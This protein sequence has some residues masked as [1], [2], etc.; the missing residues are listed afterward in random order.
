MFL[1]LS[2]VVCYSVKMDVTVFLCKT[3]FLPWI[4][5]A[6]MQLFATRVD[7]SLV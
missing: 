2:K 4:N 3:I 6:Q 5:L 1:H 7:S